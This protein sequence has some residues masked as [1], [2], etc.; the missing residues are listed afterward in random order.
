MAV[1]HPN[2]GQ[3]L[4]GAGAH[5]GLNSSGRKGH[6]QKAPVINKSIADLVIYRR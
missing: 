3:N 1:D 4:C 6:R 2:A 5:P